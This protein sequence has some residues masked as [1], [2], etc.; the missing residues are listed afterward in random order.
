MFGDED[1]RSDLRAEQRVNALYSL[2]WERRFGNVIGAIQGD[3]PRSECPAGQWRASPPIFPP[4]GC[5]PDDTQPKPAASWLSSACDP[6]GS[7]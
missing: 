7:P 6:D 3:G 4:H 1:W 5:T 2:L